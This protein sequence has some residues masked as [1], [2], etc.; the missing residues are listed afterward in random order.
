MNFPSSFAQQSDYKTNAMRVKNRVELLKRLEQVFITRTIS[1][2][3]KVL[4]PA[5]ISC[6][7][8]QTVQETFE[9][10]QVNNN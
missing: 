2:W 8:V 4:E 7:R 6:S 10:E 5:G 1:Q 9:S 3:L